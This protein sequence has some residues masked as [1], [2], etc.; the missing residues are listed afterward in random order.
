MGPWSADLPD[1]S[2]PEKQLACQR[3]RL[4]L[5]THSDVLSY[6]ATHTQA[7][8]QQQKKTPLGRRARGLKK[9]R[10]PVM[11]MKQSLLVGWGL[12]GPH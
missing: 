6:T 8:K 12:Q 10:G 4:Y 9:Q 1:V 11:S 2:P 5:N 7:L 3:A